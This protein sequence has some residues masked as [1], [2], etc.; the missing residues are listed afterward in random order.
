LGSL[1]LIHDKT[2]NEPVSPFWNS[3]LR[4]ELLSVPCS[5]PRRYRDDL[6]GERERGADG[7]AEKKEISLGEEMYPS[8]KPQWIPGVA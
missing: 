8:I 6:I 3:A 7:A 5:A 4:D 1:A 2:K